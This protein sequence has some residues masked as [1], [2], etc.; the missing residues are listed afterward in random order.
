MTKKS[1]CILFVYEM[2]W[3]K[4]VIYEI[5][6]IPELLSSFGHK[7][8]VF[9]YEGE[10]KIRGLRDIF[11][12]RTKKWP[13]V[14]RAYDQGHVTVYRPGFVKIPG[15]SRLSAM[16]TN[17]VELNRLMRQGEIDA[18]ILYSVPTQGLQT[19]YLAA[20]YRIPVIFRVIDIMNQFVP[21]RWLV[22]P[23]IAVERKIYRKA[24]LVLA[25]T[26]QLRYYVAQ[27]GA[28]RERIKICG[29]GVYTSLFRPNLNVS[30]LREK[31]NLDVDDKVII[32]VG[33]L[34]EFSGVK[35]FVSNFA[36]LKKEIPNVKFCIVGEGS[37]YKS[38]K[39]EVSQKNLENDVIMTGW[40]NY[41]EVPEYINLAH[42]CLVPFDINPTTNHI[43]PQK[44]LQYLAC[45]KPVVSSALQGTMGLLPPE[46]S[47][48]LYAKNQDELITHI[49]RIL[50][51]E[52]YASRLKEN[53]RRMVETHYRWEVITRQFEKI[54]SDLVES[55]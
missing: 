31:H 4:K 42:V 35:K 12:L 45:A 51:D 49:R 1:L 15:F 8:I 13:K 50:T 41:K 33:T 25:M 55:R 26:E 21:Y 18:V 9:D 39:E 52:S 53:G 16:I 38:I 28:P 32:F 47:G 19:I 5:H 29:L 27:R 2:D 14:S 46:K 11:Q 30:H 10:W 20:R 24:D 40:V 48:V 54:V 34:F 43:T 17:F 44:I 22:W 36:T 23:T 7:I 6:H 37:Q 3:L